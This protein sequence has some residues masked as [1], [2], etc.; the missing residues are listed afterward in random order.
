MT[1][2]FKS[3][4]SSS[5]MNCLCYQKSMPLLTRLFSSGLG[6]TRCFHQFAVG[7][8]DCSSGCPS[9][10]CSM[11]SAVR[12]TALQSGG[13]PCGES[14][15]CG[16]NVS[17]FRTQ[18]IFGFHQRFFSSAKPKTQPSIDNLSR[19]IEN[20][21]K[22]EVDENAFG[23]VI[24]EKSLRMPDELQASLQETGFNVSSKPGES[25]ISLVKETPSEII[26]AEFDIEQIY[27]QE[28]YSPEMEDG[29]TNAESAENARHNSFDVAFNIK[30]KDTGDALKGSVWLHSDYADLTSLRFV[31]SQSVSSNEQT[32]AYSGP[33]LSDLDET[34]QENLAKYLQS[35][36]LDE[37]LHTF[38]SGFADFKESAEYYNW[39]GGLKRF[40]AK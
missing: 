17:A 24:T 37:R 8:G 2:I 26:T 31:P 5:M 30:R 40:F 15:A 13:C 11:A 7:G 25:I 4:T 36:G 39:L 38:L 22:S 1:R 9:S 34:L 14:G 23:S 19:I 12:R 18:N 33:N 10:G 32:K 35:K 27:D 28:Q 20:E 6:A 29:D 21:M 3:L 16:N